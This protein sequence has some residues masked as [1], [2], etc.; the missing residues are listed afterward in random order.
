MRNTEKEN[1]PRLL[2]PAGNWEHMEM[3]ADYGADAVYLAGSSFGMRATAANFGGDTLARAVRY[4]AAHGVDVHVVCNTLPRNEEFDR[5]PAFLEEV[6]DAGAAA[7]IVTDLG[8][9]RLAQRYAPGVKLHVSTQAGIVNYESARMWHEL[10]AAQV[11]LARELTLDE[12]AEIRAKTPHE[13]KLEVFVHGAMCVS[14][15]GRCLLSN[16]MANRD[17]NRGQC[18]QPCRWRYALMEETRPGQYFPVFEEEEGSYILNA[19]DLCMIGHIPEVLAAGADTLKIEGRA[20][21][22]Y[23]TAVITNAYRHALD[24]ARRGEPLEPVWMEEVHKVSHR[25]YGTGFFFGRQK[26]GEF[27]EYARYLRPW[28]VAAFV[29]SCDETGEALL[30]QKNS[31]ACGEELELLA[32]GGKPIRFRADGLRDAEGNPIEKAPHPSMKL[33]LRLPA[34]VP[35]RAILRRENGEDAGG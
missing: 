26:D 25:H 6:R 16:Y 31:F 7:L 19:R 22:S 13:L 20:K 23:Y 33:R 35:R 34:V 1:A 9:F 15:S 4:C 17:S 12:I 30:T 14:F 10:G 8:V 27:Y 3:A 29:D 32:P 11:I 2:A 24:A 18:A 21:T 28:S 5:L